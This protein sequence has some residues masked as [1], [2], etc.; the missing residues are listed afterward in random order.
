M[1]KL[2]KL[3]RLCAFLGFFSAIAAWVALAFNEYVCIGL[4]IASLVLAIAG[5]WSDKGLWRNL[6]ITAI[7][8]A[9][10]LLLVVFAFLFGLDY[11]VSKI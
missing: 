3:W 8:A 11:V 10:V 2:L 7:I 9:A 5:C 1:E 6:G 4:G